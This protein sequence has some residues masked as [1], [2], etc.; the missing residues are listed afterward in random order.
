MVTFASPRIRL[1]VFDLGRVLLRICNGW[2][3]ACRRAGVN[4]QIDQ[5]DPSAFEIVGSLSRFRHDW[6]DQLDPRRLRKRTAS[7]TIRHHAGSVPRP[8][9]NAYLHYAFPG[10][11]DLLTELRAKKVATACLSNTNES[12]W[13]MMNDPSDAAHLPLE[14]LNHRFASHLV[15]ARKPEAAIY[16]HVEQQTTIPPQAILFFDDVMEN[17]EAAQHRGWQTFHVDP[18][19][20]NPIPTI[21]AELK[22]RALL[23]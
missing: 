11:L 20:E 22:R 6:R 8:I 1:V 4:I 10:T 2:D 9:S 7:P 12:H 14:H 13:R 5:L 18:R 17:I 21:R 16:E 19:L 23:P 15:R 3:D